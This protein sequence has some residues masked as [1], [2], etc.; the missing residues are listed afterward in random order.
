MLVEE[1]VD[2]LEITI[3]RASWEIGEKTQTARTWIGS[4][5]AGNETLS[6]GIRVDEI[7]R[8]WVV[9]SICC[10]GGREEAI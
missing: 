3:W 10:S 1:W 8:S 5:G 9:E 6:G 7:K 2:C 4:L